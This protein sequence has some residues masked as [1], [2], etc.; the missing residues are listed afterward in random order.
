MA[1]PPVTTTVQ[2]GGS[3]NPTFIIKC[4]DIYYV[5]QSVA[6]YDPSKASTDIQRQNIKLLGDLLDSAS[7][8]DCHCAKVPPANNIV[9]FQQTGP[10]D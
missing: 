10:N 2:L 7:E 4:G 3:N 8:C 1:Q 6:V 5:T 9:S